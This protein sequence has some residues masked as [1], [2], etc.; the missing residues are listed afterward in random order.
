MRKLALL[1]A[2]CGL[3]GAAGGAHAQDEFTLQLKWVTQA[4]FAGYYYALDHGYYEEEGLDVTIQP[5]AA[6][7]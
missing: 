1:G 4:Q 5:P 6:L 3:F 7:T 2:A